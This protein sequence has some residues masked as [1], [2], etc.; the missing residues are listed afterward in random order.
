MVADD[1]VNRLR[2]DIPLRNAVYRAFAEGVEQAQR[3]VV[4]TEALGITNSLAYGRPT[5]LLSA[6]QVVRSPYPK[7]WF[8][9]E[10][11]DASEARR[12]YD[13]DDPRPLEDHESRIRRVGI[14]V[15]TIGDERS[16]I[17]M[18]VVQFVDGGFRLMMHCGTADFAEDAPRDGVWTR[19]FD[20][21][22]Q[23][24]YDRLTGRSELAR[25]REKHLADPKERSAMME[26]LG[27][28]GYAVMP[29]M[30]EQLRMVGLPA[31]TVTGLSGAG[32][33][34]NY[35]GWA[36]R[37]AAKTLVLHNLKNGVEVRAAAL[38]DE[39]QRTR[40]R[41]NRP[42]LLDHHVLGLRL[43]RHIVREEAGGFS[44]DAEDMRAHWVRGH[45]KVRST[46][47]Y[48]WSP[49]IRGEP[50]LGFVDKTYA[51]RP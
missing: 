21:A 18:P 31:S 10:Q 41:L 14:L 47:V 6:M 45:L 26:Y 9:Y 36:A 48:W 27:R 33:E 20:D 13:G 4:T 51:L 34:I 29:H 43:P 15:E 23:L 30:A 17:A 38:S 35:A 16:Y 28:F 7:V 42:P 46:G 1:V 19:R 22:K 32:E 37:E 44:G 12:R 39:A 25:R 5:T 11:A 2:S 40:R 50:A 3:F 8:E 49:H 24:A